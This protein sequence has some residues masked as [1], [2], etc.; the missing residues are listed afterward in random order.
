MPRNI[1]LAFL[2]GTPISN[3]VAE[4]YLVLRNLVP[5]QLKEMGLDNFDAWRSM[6]VSYASA[7]EP[8]ESGSVK[9]VTRLGREWMNMRSLMDSTTPWR[10]LSPSRTSKGLR[11]RQSRQEVPGSGCPFRAH[12]QGRPRDGSR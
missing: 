6:Y 9:E 8:T 1:E 12:R 10:M 7:Y 2:T 11:R 4:M 5:D 3:S